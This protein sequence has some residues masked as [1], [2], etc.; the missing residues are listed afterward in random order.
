MGNIIDILRER[1]YIAQTT[2]EDELYEAFSNGPVTFY[3]GFDPTADSLHIG[4]Y[5][6]LMRFQYG[7]NL[8]YVALQ[9]V[10]TGHVDFL[11]EC[12]AY[13]SFHCF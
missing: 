13:P 9:T 3:N 10:E 8:V 2:F 11:L 4:H 12:H 1:G 5:V 6:A 7:A